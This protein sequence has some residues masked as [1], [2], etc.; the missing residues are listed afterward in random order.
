[1]GADII[2][3]EIL[4]DGTIKAVTDKISPANHVSADLFF[5]LLQKDCGGARNEKARSLHTHTHEGITHSH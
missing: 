5:R 1:M 3:I 2:N 4:E